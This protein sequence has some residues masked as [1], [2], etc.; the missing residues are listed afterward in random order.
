MSTKTSSAVTTVTT[1]TTAT[2]KVDTIDL[3]ASDAEKALSKF[4][5]AREAIKALEVQKE[6]A[7]ARLRELLGDAEVGMIRGV[8][9]FKLQHSSNTKIDRKA[10]E[11][12]WPEAYAATLVKTPYDFIKAL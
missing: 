3:T 9:R 10:L 8:E 5:A 4:I 7:E 2:T 12:G 11:A 6:E 1:V